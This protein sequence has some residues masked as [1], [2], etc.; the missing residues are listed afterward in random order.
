[1]A[2]AYRRDWRKEQFWRDRLQ[3]WRRSGQTVRA[4]CDERRLSEASFYGWRRELGRRDCGARG[5]RQARRPRQRLFVP[6]QVMDSQG[7]TSPS[8][9]GAVGEN[10]PHGGVEVVL[11]SGRCLRVQPGFDGP[12]L[13]AVVQVLEGRPC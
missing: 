2:R 8:S 10:S 3:E 13:A 4:Y 5:G 12:T 1:M 9:N 11:A 6:V 7:A